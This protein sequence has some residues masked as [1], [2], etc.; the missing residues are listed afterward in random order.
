MPEGINISELDNEVEEIDFKIVPDRWALCLI[1][2]PGKMV[3][4][5]ETLSTFLAPYGYKPYM[6]GNCVIVW[7]DP[8][9]RAEGLEDVLRKIRDAL[10]GVQ[11]DFPQGR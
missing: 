5:M 3:P 2:Y 11:I 4:N 7:N 8:E 6:A 1:R 10:P 9:T